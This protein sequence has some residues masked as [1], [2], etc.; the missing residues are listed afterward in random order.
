MLEERK[1]PDRYHCNSQIEKCT[2]FLELLNKTE[3]DFDEIWYFRN[4][5]YVN[6]FSVSSMK[7]TETKYDYNNRNKDFYKKRLENKINHYIDLLKRHDQSDYIKDNLNM[8][9]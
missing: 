3:Y 8:F 6:I 9:I 5:T 7:P 4:W 2:K 1:I